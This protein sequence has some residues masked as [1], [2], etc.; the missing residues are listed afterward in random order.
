MSARQINA[1][2]RKIWNEVSSARSE[3]KMKYLL[4]TTDV[5]SPLSRSTVGRFD[6]TLTLPEQL[7]LYGVGFFVF[8]SVGDDASTRGGLCHETQMTTWHIVL[9]GNIRIVLCFGE[10]SELQATWA[11]LPTLGYLPKSL[12]IL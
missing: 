6:A 2:Y 9:V 3:F 12:S 10:R 8:F 7:Q 5:Y 1:L 4:P 11:L